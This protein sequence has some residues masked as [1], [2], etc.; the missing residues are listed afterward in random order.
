MFECVCEHV[1][2][3]GW[4]I[5]A[6]IHCTHTPSH[7][8]QVTE[9]Q[10]KLDLT[11][12]SIM[13]TTDRYDKLVTIATDPYEAVTRAHAMVVCT[14]WDEFTTLDYHRIYQVM[15]KPA[16]VFDGRLI[17][18]HQKLLD[19]GFQVEAIGKVVMATGTPTS[20]SAH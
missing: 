3:R 8:H 19:I 14:E 10:I 13:P 16:F 6:C 2:V 7:P 12:P 4:S 15:E 1:C 5:H 9:E 18:D 17:L 20:N 11:D